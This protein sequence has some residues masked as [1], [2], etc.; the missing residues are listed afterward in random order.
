[1][2]NCG[3]VQPPFAECQ[4]RSQNSERGRWRIQL[5]RN[6]ASPLEHITTQTHTCE[7]T[8]RSAWIEK[9]CHD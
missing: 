8:S 7:H 2:L 1:M 6:S 4:L 9:L 3:A 5:C